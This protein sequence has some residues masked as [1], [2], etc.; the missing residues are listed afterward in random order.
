MQFSNVAEQSHFQYSPFLHS[1]VNA[2]INMGINV[3]VLNLFTQIEYVY[4]T[5][6]FRQDLNA[7]SNVGF[8]RNIYT[9][10]STFIETFAKIK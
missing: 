5:H 4:F 3:Q 9:L 7:L 2:Q 6:L 1:I 10:H 8:M